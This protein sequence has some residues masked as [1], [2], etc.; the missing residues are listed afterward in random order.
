MRI[1]GCEPLSGTR[2]RGTFHVMRLRTTVHYLV[3][4]TFHFWK[5]TVLT[6]RTRVGLSVG[7]KA[8]LESVGSRDQ[9]GVGELA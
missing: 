4:S 5:L 8:R 6:T 1:K 9:G 2:A 7:T 3:R